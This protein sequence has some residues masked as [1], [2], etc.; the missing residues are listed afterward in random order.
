MPLRSDVARV[1]RAGERLA[2]VTLDFELDYGDRIGAFNIL[3]DDAERIEA[4]AALC[5]QLATPVSAFVP[6][7]V[8]ERYPASLELLRLLADDVHAHSHTHDTGNFDS[9]REIGGSAEAFERIFGRRPLGYR[10][11]QGV[12]RDGDVEL[13]A[14]L[15]YCFSASVFPSYRPGKF[16]NLGL[17]NGPFVYHNGIVEL[18]FAAVPRVRAP[19]ALS[20]LKL[21]GWRLNRALVAAFGLPEVVVFNTHLHDFIVNEQS[22]SRLPARMRL[23]WGINKHRGFDYF[24]RFVELL[25]GRGYRFVTMTE[26]Y[27]H[28]LRIDQLS[29]PR[30]G[31]INQPGA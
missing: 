18:S 19:L 9:R 6:T 23:A 11:P 25:R 2:C 26:L 1:L 14:E 29:G 16:N 15:G 22:Y 13:L 28:L 4:L 8:L 7:S 30:S 12:L 21:L 31:D 3:R 10:A 24:A 20:Y 5:R 27:E 17:P